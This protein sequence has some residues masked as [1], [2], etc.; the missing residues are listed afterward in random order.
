MSNE[1]GFAVRPR[2]SISQDQIKSL[3]TLK[4]TQQAFL[5]HPVGYPK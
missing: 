1:P 3:L 4:E 2:A 5:N